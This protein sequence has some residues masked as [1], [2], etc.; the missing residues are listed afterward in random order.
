L[1]VCGETSKS[2]KSKANAQKRVGRIRGPRV[3]GMPESPV[4]ADVTWPG[5]TPT[6]VNSKVT[7]GHEVVG[8]GGTVWPVFSCLPATC[9]LVLLWSPQPFHRHLTPTECLAAEVCYL[10]RS[11]SALLLLPP[12]SHKCHIALSSQDKRTQP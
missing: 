4:L 1:L 12:S 11:H 7:W 3:S 9:Q 8:E 2:F 5:L 6:K 10:P